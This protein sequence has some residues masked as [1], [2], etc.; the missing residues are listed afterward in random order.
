MSWQ[1]A[2]WLMLGGS[3]AL[4]FLGLPVAFAFLAINLVGAAIYLGGEPGLVQ[5]A[6]NGVQSVTSFALTPITT[7]SRSA[8]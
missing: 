4:M 7:R 2:A 8:R 1:A 6:R 3:T 5:F